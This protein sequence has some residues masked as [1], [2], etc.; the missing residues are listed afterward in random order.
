M[1]EYLQDHSAR[2]EFNPNANFVCAKDYNIQHELYQR[3]ILSDRKSNLRAKPERLNHKMMGQ[4]KTSNSGDMQILDATI[5]TIPSKWQELC[6]LKLSSD[7]DGQ[8]LEV[9]GQSLHA[10]AQST[11]VLGPTNPHFKIKLMNFDHFKYMAVGFSSKGHLTDQVPGLYEQSMGYDSTG[12]LIANNISKKVGMEWKVGD[13]IECGIKYPDNFVDNRRVNVKLYFKRNEQFV[14][15]TKVLMPT[16]GYFPT[17]YM[18]EG[19]LGSWWENGTIEKMSGTNT[20]VK[21]YE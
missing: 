16:G 14:A 10:F 7:E 19:V 3:S 11:S 21:F 9:E 18:F 2:C 20:R 4:Q 17:I 1:L 5:F 8:V 6:N 15:E 12:D 13:V